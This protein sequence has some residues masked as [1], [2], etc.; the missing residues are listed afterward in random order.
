[1]HAH[2]AK[3]AAS[4]FLPGAILASV[5]ATGKTSSTPFEKFVERIA[6]SN[7]KWLE[8]IWN[9][10]VQQYGVI[11]TVWADYDFYLDG[12]FSHCGIDAFQMLKTE[13]GWKIAAISDSRVTDGCEQ[14]PAGPPKS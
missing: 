6:T 11:A 4:L 14:N 13:S 8:R 3:A 2:D 9:P 5:D 12:K 7:K 10:K 1:M